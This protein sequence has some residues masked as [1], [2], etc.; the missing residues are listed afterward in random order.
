M[1]T[2]QALTDTASATRSFAIWA[3]LAFLALRIVIDGRALLSM[4][5][6]IA[7][8]PTA[9]RLYNLYL[10]ATSLA[11]F[12]IGAV[13]V[14]MTLLWRRNQAGLI[15]AAILFVAE[16]YSSILRD[17]TG[18]VVQSA[19]GSPATEGD[20]IARALGRYSMLVAP[21]VLLAWCSFG[22]SSKRYFRHAL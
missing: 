13:A 19:F 2:P 16:L 4:H 18:G 3:L 5:A 21:L 17:I 1:N 14:A 9:S 10:S 12:R 6:V 15:I 11:L 8:G 20:A 22:S 7:Q